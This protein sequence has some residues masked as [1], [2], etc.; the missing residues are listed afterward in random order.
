MTPKTSDLTTDLTTDPVSEPVAEPTADPAAGPATHANADFGQVAPAL[1][2]AAHAITGASCVLFDFDGPICGLF[3][4]HRA[5]HI[6]ERLIGWLTERGIV[7]PLAEAERRDPHAVLRAV[8]SLHPEDSAVV[9]GLE[10]ALTEEELHATASAAPTPYVDELI[11][12]WSARGVPLAVATNN[13]PLAVTRYVER[14]GLAECFDRHVYGRTTDLA[15]LKPDPDCLNRALRALGADP[16]KSLMIGDTPSDLYAAQRAGV[17]F[18]GYAKD[19]YRV[20]RLRRAG[21]ETV[22]DTLAEV[23][24]LVERG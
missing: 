19:E 6:A 13:S 2:R 11:R 16:A 22:V 7:V 15:R 4:G 3:A 20:A 24:G 9:R 10:Q 14:R 12:R 23:L 17:A 18:L 8:G 5:P 21:A 1:E